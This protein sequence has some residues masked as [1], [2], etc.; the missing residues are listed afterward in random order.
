[1]VTAIGYDNRIL[2]QIPWRVHGLPEGAD[3]AL[4]SAPRGS[5]TFLPGVEAPLQVPNRRKRQRKRRTTV[6]TL[7]GWEWGA[8][9]GMTC[10][11]ENKYKKCSECGCCALP[12]ILE[13]L[14]VYQASP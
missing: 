6:Q 9:L 8:F 14:E 4:L 12:K 3:S 7:E 13:P 10:E 2:L 1:M 5:F 11:R